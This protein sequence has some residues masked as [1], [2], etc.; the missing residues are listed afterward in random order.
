MKA[1]TKAAIGIA[2]ALAIGGTVAAFVPGVRGPVNRAV[3]TANEKLNDEYVVDNYKAEAIAL[4][5]KL[6]D[7]EKERK[8]IETFFEGYNLL[9]HQHQTTDVAKFAHFDETQIAQTL[10][11]KEE[12]NALLSQGLQQLGADENKHKRLCALRE[13]LTGLF[14]RVSS[15]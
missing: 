6:G 7:G 8:M 10:A 12:E 14:A 1:T 4:V 13:K 11:E 2:A 3:I 5:E 9:V 15:I